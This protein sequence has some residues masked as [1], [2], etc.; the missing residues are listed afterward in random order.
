MSLVGRALRSTFDFSRQI[1]PCL[2]QI[3][4]SISLLTSP[5]DVFHSIAKA[6][7]HVLSDRNTLDSRRM[8]CVVPRV[9]YRVVLYLS[10][11]VNRDRRFSLLFGFSI[12]DS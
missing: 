2:F 5:P 3:L 9:V 10:G 8:F 6:E 7:A 4:D 12:H 11:G 1:P